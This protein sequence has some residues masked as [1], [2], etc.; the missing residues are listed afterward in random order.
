MTI[1]VENIGKSQ[2]ALELS[3]KTLPYPYW[4]YKQT[5]YGGIGLYRKNPDGISLTTN[6]V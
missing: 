1:I 2:A 5:I 3:L 4:D 6:H